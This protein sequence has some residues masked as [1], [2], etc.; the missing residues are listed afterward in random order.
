MRRGWVQAGRA[1]LYLLNVLHQTPSRPAS[2]V[3]SWPQW[4]E[5]CPSNTRFPL[6]SLL[7]RSRRAAGG[8]FQGVHPCLLLCMGLDPLYV[9]TKSLTMIA[10]Q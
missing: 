3:C 2:W 4:P 10:R 5:F 8:A 1:L 6:L 7:L 9:G